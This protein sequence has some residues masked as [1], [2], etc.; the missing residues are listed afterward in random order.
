MT[1]PCL[2]KETSSLQRNLLDGYDEEQAKKLKTRVRMNPV[3]KWRE[4]YCALFDVKP[5]SPDIPSPCKLQDL[6]Q[7]HPKIDKD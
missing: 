6:F 3:E 7:T 5:D 1:T 4:W 2:V